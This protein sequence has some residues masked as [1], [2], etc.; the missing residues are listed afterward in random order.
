MNI[1]LLYPEYLLFFLALPVLVWLFRPAARGLPRWRKV[2]LLMTRVGVL[3][4]L[5]LG[6]S[7]LSLTY[8]SRAV[9]VLFVVDFSASV[10]SE[11]RHQALQYVQQAIEA[12]KAEDTAGLVV[13]GAEPSLESAPHRSWAVETIHSTVNGEGTNIAKAIQLALASF[14]AAGKRRMVLLT[15]GNATMGNALEAA[16]VAKSLGVEIST[17]PLSTIWKDNE[18]RLE[19]VQAPE[20]VR[21]NERYEVQVVVWSREESHGKLVFLKNGYFLEERDISLRPGKNNLTFVDVT[22]EEGLYTYEAVINTSNDQIAENNR[23]ATFTEVLGSPKVLL[24]YEGKLESPQ[25]VEALQTQGIAIE[26][27]SWTEIPDT[28]HGLLKYDAILFDNVSGLGLSLAKME[29]LER[30]VRDG[31]GGFIM[32]GGD[33]S[34]GAG[35]YYQT[36]L[37]EMLP[38]TMDIP[39]RMTVPSLSMV[40]V[41]D[42]SDSMG[43]YVDETS[44][45]GARE[46]A[47]TKLE[48]AKMASFAAIKLLNPFDQVGLVAFNTDYQ[49]IVPITE[50][51]KREQIAYK[52][53]A[54]TPS[55]GTDLYVGL[56]EGF[57]QLSQIRA[58]KKHLIALSDGLTQKMDFRSLVARMVAEKITVSTVALGEDADRQLLRDIAEWGGG[59]SYYTNDPMNIPRIF[60]TETVLVSRGFVE[61][62]NFQPQLRM[63]SAIFSGI[64]WQQIPPLRGYVLAYAKPTA[65]TLL[66][67]DKGDPLLTVWRYG[68]GRSVAFTSDLKGRWGKAWLQWE[69]FNQLVGQL[70]RWTQRQYSP[71]HLQSTFQVADHQGTIF[72]DVLNERGEF[73]NYLV[74]N[75]TVVLPDR[76]RRE[77]P[78][79]QTAPGRY[80][81]TFPLVGSGEYYVTLSGKGSGR[82]VG[83]KT[84]GLAVPY[85]PEYLLL[86]PNRALLAQIA[87]LTGGTMASL[88]TNIGRE[89]FTATEEDL[90]A[91]QEIWFPL[92]L[93][94]LLLFFCDILLRKL[95]LPEHL[96]RRLTTFATQW[97]ERARPAPPS[98]EELTRTLHEQG[99]SRRKRERSQRQLWEIDPTNAARFY[100]ARMRGEKQ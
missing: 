11:S 23:A 61:E 60:T 25:L 86:E 84:F 29:L 9:H 39:S 94:A 2:L 51:G 54:L 59:R 24:A 21:S 44:R 27:R 1:R 31:G 22:T 40:L 36:P 57:R 78:L 62:R 20:K 42:R 45:F 72:T 70:V 97:T 64:D 4:L 98:Y 7:G 74:L 15:D 99:E 37:E 43:G 68:L 90:R 26:P 33:R 28:L 69:S 89:L 73:V 47:A 81:G 66:V 12:M 93:A 5:V 88:D 53:S 100:V 18:V 49:W 35:G 96:T 80:Q 82:E 77:L 76:S 85:A 50:A 71:E 79:V 65:E 56:E 30:Y 16:I 83:P 14:P 13:F 46:R 92:A 19:S 38:V 10:G 91:Y 52:L 87:S 63:E 48:V 75:G 95:V 32:L 41:I 8:S 67:T 6:L 17:V 34:F 58:M 55:G 3:S